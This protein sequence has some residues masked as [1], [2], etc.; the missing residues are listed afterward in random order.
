MA[1]R[2][3]YSRI[4]ILDPELTVL[5]GYEDENVRIDHVTV[6]RDKMEIH[7]YTLTDGTYAY[8]TPD[9][10]LRSDG[11]EADPG[12]FTAVTYGALMK[13]QVLR[14][15]RLP[16]S[17]RIEQNT[18]RL[19][20]EGQRLELP[21]AHQ[22]EP[23]YFRYFAY[24]SDELPEACPTLGDAIAAAKTAYGFVLSR[25]GSLAWYWAGKLDEKI[26]EISSGILDPGPDWENVSGAS[27]REL[28][29]FL[30]QEQ[31]VRWVSPGQD[32]LWLIGYEWKNVV[33][34]NPKNANVFR[35]LQSDFDEAIA[36]DNNY[37]WIQA[38]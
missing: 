36:R 26:L 24:G 37:L 7:R 32:D 30:N 5:T 19:F 14:L 18:T 13:M 29:T 12:Y 17:L 16:S 11:Q 23:Y 10:M 9:I 34:Y 28:I 38:P 3:P 31:P 35:M 33:L 27:L 22:E 21:A 6:L 4:E 20:A 1:P 2:L 25:D 8:L 15:D